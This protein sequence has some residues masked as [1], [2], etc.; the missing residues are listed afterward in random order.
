MA[1]FVFQKNRCLD[2]WLVGRLF[3]E[4][5]GFHLDPTEPVKLFKQIFWKFRFVCIFNL[6]AHP[7][8]GQIIRVEYNAKGILKYHLPIY[9]YIFYIYSPLKTSTKSGQIYLTWIIWE[10]GCPRKIQVLLV[11]GFN[12]LETYESNWKPSPNRGENK[13]C[14]KPPPRLLYYI[15][16]TNRKVNHPLLHGWCCC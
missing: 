2:S 1:T 3:G 7:I 4:F 10:L 6:P 5:N 15:D 14:L 8:D 13:K 11:G 16:A 9:I 12:P